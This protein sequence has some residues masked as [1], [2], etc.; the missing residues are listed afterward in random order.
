MSDLEPQKIGQDPAALT[1]W[2]RS[3]LAGEMHRRV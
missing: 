2:A 3:A 1:E